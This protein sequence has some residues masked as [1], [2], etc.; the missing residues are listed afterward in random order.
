MG[1]FQAFSLPPPVRASLLILAA[2][3]P[4]GE[5]LRDRLQL[6]T[7]VGL[8]GCAGAL[9]IV[10][11]NAGADLF[12]HPYE[13]R[14]TEDIQARII[15]T[16]ITLVRRI[17]IALIILVTGAAMLMSW[18]GARAIGVSLFASAGVGGLIIG[19][20]ARPAIS[21]LLAGVQIALTNPLRIDDVVIVENEWGRIEEIGGAFVTVRI[22]DDR[23][24][25][26]PL[27]YFI[28][29]PFQNW[30]RTSSDLMGTVFLHV[31]YAVQLAPLRQELTRLLRQSPLWDGRVGLLQV[32]EAS[33]KSL[34]LRILVSAADAPTLWDLRCFIREGLLDHLYAHQAAAL[35]QIRLRPFDGARAKS[36]DKSGAYGEASAGEGGL[37]PRRQGA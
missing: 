14:I 11:L 20:A 12:R 5:V 4:I 10:A 21:N 2:I 34:Q 37:R 24:L 13:S 33:E 18:P 17:L 16:Q 31:D 32:T 27:T 29:K 25:V 22:W 28:E 35:P 30:T 36:E 1:N 15:V 7:G 23:R 6:I 3:L 9:L 26:V 19:M 8:I